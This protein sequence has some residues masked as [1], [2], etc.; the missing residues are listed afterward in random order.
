MN[1]LISATP[2]EFESRYFGSRC[3]LGPSYL[4]VKNSDEVSAAADT[5]TRA[6]DNL[7]DPSRWP[8]LVARHV[9]HRA[10]LRARMGAPRQRANAAPA[11]AEKAAEGG[12]RA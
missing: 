1:F 2:L 12:G 5:R 6:N 4:T 8:G 3:V 7:A 11:A 9:S 10:A